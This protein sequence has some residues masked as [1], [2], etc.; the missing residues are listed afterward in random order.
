MALG[1][2][3]GCIIA[4]IAYLSPYMKLAYCWSIAFNCIR[5]SIHCGMTREHK[6]PRPKL[7]YF[8][9]MVGAADVVW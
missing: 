8:L 6:Q 9:V 5:E 4:I 3:S 7:E 1:L 2:D